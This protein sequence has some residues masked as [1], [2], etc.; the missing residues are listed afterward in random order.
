[1]NRFE[2]VLVCVILAGCAPAAPKA[3]DLPGVASRVA[4][5]VAAQEG[6][7]TIPVPAIG[8]GPLQP[9][10]MGVKY[11][12]PLFIGGGSTFDQDHR[13]DII[14]DILDALEGKP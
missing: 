12:S 14:R 1:M 4:L 8:F 9:D 2:V 5:A 7:A 13:R 6:T 11:I 10:V 3:V